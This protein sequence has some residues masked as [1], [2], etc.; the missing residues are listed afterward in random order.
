M[1]LT[2]LDEL[3]LF[4]FTISGGSVTAMFAIE[5]ES[6]PDP[7]E[8]NAN[9][10]FTVSEDG[11]TVTE[12]EVEAGSN[13]AEVRTYTLLPSGFF[14]LTDTQYLDLDDN[15]VVIPDDPTDDDDGIDDD[16]DDDGFDDDVVDGDEE[17]DTYAGG[18]GDDD[19]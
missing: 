15:G 13:Y 7:I 3:E 14:A 2:N 5:E 12:R 6:E 17:D 18:D 9:Q 16:L 1:Q 10:V 11:T 19:I 4:S 8:L